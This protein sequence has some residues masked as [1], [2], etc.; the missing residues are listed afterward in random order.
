MEPIGRM[1]TSLERLEF[2]QGAD[3]TDGEFRIQV[4]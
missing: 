1:M 2:F 4:F 3:I